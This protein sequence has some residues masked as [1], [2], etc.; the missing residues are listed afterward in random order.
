M[1]RETIPIPPK[2]IVLKQVEGPRW[3]VVEHHFHNGNRLFA[4]RF[5]TARDFIPA[6]HAALQASKRT[7]LPIA[8]EATGGRL[9]PFKPLRDMVVRKAHS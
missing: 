7:N 9:R 5:A 1:T 6:C 4:G 2:L 3:C 8:I